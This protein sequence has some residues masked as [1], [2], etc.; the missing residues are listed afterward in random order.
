MWQPKIIIASTNED[1]L[2]YLRLGKKLVR[3][4]GFSCHE[5]VFNYIDK[6][7]LYDKKTSIKLYKSL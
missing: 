1:S 2:L 7:K 6:H 4:K 3:K 5:D